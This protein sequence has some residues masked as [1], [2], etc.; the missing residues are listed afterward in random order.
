MFKFSFQMKYIVKLRAKH[1]GTNTK[2]VHGWGPGSEMKFELGK[3]KAADLLEKRLRSCLK[4]KKNKRI[5]N[6]KNKNKK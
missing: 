3:S 6:K 4:G 2:L 5:I 1:I